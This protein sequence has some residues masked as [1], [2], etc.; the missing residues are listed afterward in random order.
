MISIIL[1]S[2]NAHITS[3]LNN[4]IQNT[5]GVEYELIVVD[6][7]KN[8]YSIFS[9]YNEGVKRAKFP[10]LCFMHDDILFHTS[11]WGRKV[12]NHFQNTKVGL[13]GTMGSHFMPKTPIGWYQS[14]VTSGGGLQRVFKNGK[15]SVE[16]QMDL[17]YLKDKLSIEGVVV[18]GLW[19]CIPK[20]MFSLVSFDEL[21][22]KGFH[23]YDLDIC[24]Q[25]RNA[26]FQVY[27]ISDILI[28]HFSSGSFTTDWVKNTVLFFEKWKDQLPQVAGVELSSEEMTVRNDLVAE[29]FIWME[30][31]IQCKTELESVRRSKAY[32]IGKYVIMPFKYIRGFSDIIKLNNSHNSNNHKK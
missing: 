27:I 24:L 10:F 4:N 19:F 7:S 31:Y 20:S 14:R 18:D 23:C 30:A 12:I 16:K 13:I 28:E 9:A 21:T 5:I 1:C 15:Y 2:R 17:I 11:D 6:N 3:E 22:F 26:G 25:I 32:R 29:T 8:K